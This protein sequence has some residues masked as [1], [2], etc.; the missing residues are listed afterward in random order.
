[1]AT[2]ENPPQAGQADD[3]PNLDDFKEYLAYVNRVSG[4]LQ[5]EIGESEFPPDESTDP[6]STI[7]PESIEFLNRERNKARIERLK[8]DNEQRKILAKWTSDIVQNWLLFVAL[9]LFLNRIIQLSDV[10]L[11]ALLGTSTLNVLGLSYIV[12]RG[13]FNGKNKK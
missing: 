7:S 3:L 13:H 9:M 4:N 8:D 11:V 1:M 5:E 6:D 12:L 2:N 10:V